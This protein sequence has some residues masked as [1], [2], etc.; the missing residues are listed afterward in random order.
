MDEHENQSHKGDEGGHLHEKSFH[1]IVNLEPKEVHQERI[2]FD[3]ICRLA[4]PQGPFG[5]EYRYTVTYSYHGEDYPMFKGD[6]VE[7]KNGMIFHVG[8]TDR[9]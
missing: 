3:E 9:S 4:F 1:I 6:S 2:N 7:I 5:E 8:N